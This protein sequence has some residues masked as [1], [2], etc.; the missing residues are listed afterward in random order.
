[1]KK[2]LCLPLL[3]VF[4]SGLAFGQATSVPTCNSFDVNGVP[5]YSSTT[6][7]GTT[8]TPN[9]TDYFG[10]A[11]WANSPLPAGTI[12]GFTLLAGGS[13]YANPVVVVNDPTGSGTAGF[14]YQTNGVIW[15]AGS[16]Q[17]HSRRSHNI[18]SPSL[19]RTSMWPCTLRRFV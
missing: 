18:T 15:A 4:L 10:V 8:T 9:C 1:M 3:L 16:T 6:A 5:V 7:A 11:N 12:T 17:I 19:P 14:A 13:G 2:I